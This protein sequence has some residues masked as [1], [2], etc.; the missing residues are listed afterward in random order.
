VWAANRILL[1]F[2][3]LRGLGH[4]PQSVAAVLKVH[5]L[6]LVPMEQVRKEP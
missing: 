6:V 2:P 4:T 3:A 5:D 1:M